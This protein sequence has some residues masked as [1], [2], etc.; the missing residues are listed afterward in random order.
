MEYLQEV[1][2]PKSQKQARE[3]LLEA[4]DY[5]MVE[6]LLFHSRVAKSKRAKDIRHYQVVLLEVMYHDSP[7]PGYGGIADTLDK[8][9]EDYF[10]PGMHKI[11][12]WLCAILPP[13][14][15]KE[16]HTDSYQ[17]SLCSLPYPQCTPFKCGRLTC[18]IL[19][20][21]VPKALLTS[22]LVLTCF[23]EYLFATP[24]FFFFF[25]FA[26]KDALTVA[27]ALFT[28]LPCSEPVI[29]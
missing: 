25:F 13:L 4:T 7:L 24:L 19:S 10:F 14:P 5:L 23:S 20:L 3:L 15:D 21:P 1:T 16:S 6:G 18:M 26:K 22:W 27:T 28:C 12:T 29:L 11:I 2:L 9:K 8:I 17:G